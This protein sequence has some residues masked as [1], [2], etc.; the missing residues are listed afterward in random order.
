MPSAPIA[1]L[2]QRAQTLTSAG[3]LVGAQRVLASA[4]D[5]ADAADP[6]QADADVALAAA[7]H[8][9]ILI[10]LGDPHS[11]RQWAAYAHEAE[12]RLHGPHHER[13]LAA[14]ATHAAVLQ[15]VGHY[16]KA[17]QVYQRLVAE[18]SAR[19]GP[20]SARVLAAEADLA[21]AEHAAGQCQ[22][23]R[24]RLADAWIRHRHQHGDAAPAGIKMLARLGSMERECARDAESREHLALAQE[25]C[26]RYLP[27]DH[28]L[29]RQVA[30]LAVGESSGR[31]TCGRV[32]QSAGPSTQ[33]QPTIQQ[34]PFP[35]RPTVPDPGGEGFP[36][37][38]DPLR[39]P[40]DNRPTDPNGTV[41]QQPLYLA[42]VHQAP[43]DLMG[44]HAR[45][46]T[47]P[48]MPGHI[49]DYGP[50]GRPQPIGS[51]PASTLA[52]PPNSERLLPVRTEQPVRD[53]RRQPFLLVAVLIAGIAVA[54]AIV[55]LT[56]PDADGATGPKPTAVAPTATTVSVAPSTA[57]SSATVPVAGAPGA[58]TT[59]KLR[60]NRDS[61]ALTWVYPKDAEGPV[62]VSGG[63]T[64][65]QLRAFQQLP[66]GTADYMVYGLNPTQ[67]YCF[68]VA[69]AYAT[70]RIAASAPVCTSR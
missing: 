69:V 70:D 14:A 23:A 6:R 47:P 7:L 44:R 30:A 16:G 31:H 5:P 66:A 54:I 11:A 18:L 37:D 64:G 27:A 17:A 33:D 13:T 20:D 40:P 28:P 50:D 12:E 38:D 63:R 67:N 24:E 36:P 61:V 51:A 52:T 19:E 62:L 32:E 57:G 45:A 42:D 55:A 29:V 2:T 10:A 1:D 59:V 65:Q 39:P 3:D 48:P 22:S 68:T 60:D 35:R 8:A 26:A 25:L 43:G 58:P 9:R 53:R 15:R 49:P 41:Y 21:T 4:L 46:D 34:V 56:L